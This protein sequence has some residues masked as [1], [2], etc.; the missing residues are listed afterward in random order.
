MADRMRRRVIG[1]VQLYLNCPEKMDRIKELCKHTDYKDLMVVVTTMGGTGLP[2]KHRIRFGKGW[3]G[4]NTEIWGV[5]YLCGGSKGI[6]IFITISES[7]DVFD[8]WLESPEDRIY[9]GA[10]TD[11]LYNW[12]LNCMSWEE[13]S[14]V[15]DEERAVRAEADE[16]MAEARIGEMEM[17]EGIQME[18][19]M[20]EALYG[21][22]DEISDMFE[23]PVV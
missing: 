9:L 19:E 15:R 20:Q 2:A 17:L 21:Q 1:R 22:T 23:G 4:R 3:T 7:V 8:C 14:E 16:V 11:V 13:W 12:F 18:V 10:P 6:I 5:D